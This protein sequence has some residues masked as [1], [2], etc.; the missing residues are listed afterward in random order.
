MLAGTLI[1]SAEVAATFAGSVTVPGL[2][3]T[4]I[5]EPAGAVQ[6][7]V[8]GP[9][10]PVGEMRVSRSFRTAAVP[11]LVVRAVWAALIEKSATAR[12][13]VAVRA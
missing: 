4:A 9:L 7:K 10:S 2:H 5:P 1:A 3:D 8:T 11:P 12:E 13:T 6:L